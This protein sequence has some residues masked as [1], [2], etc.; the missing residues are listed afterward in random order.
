MLTP[1]RLERALAFLEPF[2]D[3]YAL[4][5]ATSSATR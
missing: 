5:R 2:D 4:G 1:W 3:R